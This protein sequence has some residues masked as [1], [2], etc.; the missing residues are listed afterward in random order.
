[1]LWPKPSWRARWKASS[2]FGPVTPVEPARASDVAGAALGDELLLAVDH[3][4]AG[5]GE[6]AAAEA[7]AA[8]ATIPASTS[9]LSSS[10]AESYDSRGWLCRRRADA[11]GRPSSPRAAAITVRATPSHE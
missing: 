10:G 5:I 4:G 7:T 1:M 8:A 2:R 11:A 3:V 6:V 9:A